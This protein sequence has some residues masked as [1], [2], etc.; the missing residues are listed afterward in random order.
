MGI[1]ATVRVTFI[2]YLRPGIQTVP[3]SAVSKTRQVPVV[4]DLAISGLFGHG[5]RP[6]REERILRILNGRESSP[7]RLF[8]IPVLSCVHVKCRWRTS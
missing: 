5:L 7:P 2:I 3:A 4:V 6:F 1:M 8:V